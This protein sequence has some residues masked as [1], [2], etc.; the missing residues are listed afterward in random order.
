MLN[1]PEYQQHILDNIP[2]LPITQRNLEWLANLAASAYRLGVEEALK[3][4]K[5]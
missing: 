2:D 5:K 4:A 3:S 1:P